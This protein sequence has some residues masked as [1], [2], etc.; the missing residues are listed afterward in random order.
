M[1]R[2]KVPPIRTSAAIDTPR[3]C[4][5]G[6]ESRYTASRISGDYCTDWAA[7]ELSRNAVVKKPLDSVAPFDQ[8]HGSLEYWI[9]L[10]ST[11]VA[12]PYL[13]LVASEAAR[14]LRARR[15][16]DIRME[17]FRKSVG[18]NDSRI[19]DSDESNVELLNT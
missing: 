9:N 2:H 4:R 11:N 12:V 17:S 13:K 18:V 5:R 19:K 8:S 14:K 3:P 7:V 1:N 10:D 6:L 15:N 16:L